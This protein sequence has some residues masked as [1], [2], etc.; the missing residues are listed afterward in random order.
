MNKKIEDAFKQ[1]YADVPSQDNEGYV[2]DRGSFKC[3]FVLGAEFALREAIDICNNDF[4]MVDSLPSPY[5]TIVKLY[6]MAVK[7]DLQQLLTKGE[8]NGKL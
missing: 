6:I 5:N 1:A 2:P 7:N 8:N 4:G 3:G